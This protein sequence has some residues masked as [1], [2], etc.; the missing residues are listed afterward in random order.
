MAVTEDALYLESELDLSIQIDETHT[1]GIAEQEPIEEADHLNH[2]CEPNAGIEGQIILVAMRD[3]A[4]GEEITFDYATVLCGEGHPIL[5]K[6]SFVC[7]C[8]KSCCRG[9]VTADDWKRPELRA[10]YRGWFSWYLQDRIDR[11]GC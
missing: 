1:I 7:G 6:Y 11:E 9:K 8:G 10:K 4:A 3:I 2:S 5:S